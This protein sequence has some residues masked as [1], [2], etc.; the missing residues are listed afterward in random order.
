MNQFS[1]LTLPHP[2]ARTR[3][4]SDQIRATIGIVQCGLQTL[5]DVDAFSQPAVIRV[6][7]ALKMYLTILKTVDAAVRQRALTDADRKD[8]AWIA[9][10]LEALRA[11]PWFQV[12]LS[13]LKLGL[14]PDLRS[15]GISPADQS[16]IGY[17]TLIDLARSSILNLL[18]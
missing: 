8:L 3:L 6:Q 4:S 1:Y 12:R 16:E 15:H 18:A 5:S 14:P 2:Q 17:L 11:N 9:E 7:G 10:N 13:H